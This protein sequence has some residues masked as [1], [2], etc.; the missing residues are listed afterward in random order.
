[1]RPHETCRQKVGEQ[2]ERYRE[3]ERLKE[4]EGER[5]IQ[6]RRETEKEKVGYY[7]S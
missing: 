6:G 1:M 7:I 3:T 4:R 2:R 5:D